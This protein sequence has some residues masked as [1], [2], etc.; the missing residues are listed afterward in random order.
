M[1]GPSCS[2]LS[3]FPSLPVVLSVL[4]GDLVGSCLVNVFFLT[5]ISSACREEHK[6]PFCKCWR[7]RRVSGLTRLAAGSWFPVVSGAGGKFSLIPEYR[8]LFGVGCKLESARKA[9]VRWG[10]EVGED[11][12]CWNGTCSSL[13]EM[14]VGQEEVQLLP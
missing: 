4:K 7:L 9:W 11:I 14:P 8:F 3:C 1:D 5:R 10:Q 2:H 12:R 13:M 6:R